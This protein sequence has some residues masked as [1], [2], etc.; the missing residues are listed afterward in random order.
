[1]AVLG[2]E[3]CCTLGMLT[4]SQ[5]AQLKQAGLTA[6]NHNLILLPEF[7]TNIISTRVYQERLI[8]LLP[9]GGLGITA[10]AEFRDGRTEDDRIGLLHQL[11]TLDLHPES[12]PINMLVRAEGTRRW[13]RNRISIH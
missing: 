5:A 11:A 9:C 13:R 7:Y 1:V 10:A 4:E 6:Y 2:M 3:V 8:R 12:V